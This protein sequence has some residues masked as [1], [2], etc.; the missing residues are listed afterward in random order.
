VRLVAGPR[1]GL[2]GAFERYLRLPF[3]QPE[4]VLLDAAGR[5]AAAYRAV[6]DRSAGAGARLDPVT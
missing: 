2:D 5:L 1:F 6:V 3:T 4:P